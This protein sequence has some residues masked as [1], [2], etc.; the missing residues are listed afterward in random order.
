M[1]IGGPIIGIRSE[2][3]NVRRRDFINIAAVS[4]VGVGAASATILIGTLHHGI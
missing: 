2:A 4:F 1:N 3:G